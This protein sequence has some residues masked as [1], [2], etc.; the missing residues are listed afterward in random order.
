MQMKV[1]GSIVALLIASLSVPAR[2][3]T[4]K[5]RIEFGGGYLH[6]TGDQ[7][8]DGFD[9]SAAAIFSRRVSIEFDYDGIY[10][11]SKIGVFELNPQVGLTTSKSHLQNFIIGPHISF[12]A[13]AIRKT[14]NL[15]PFVDAQFGVSHL[16]S[17]LSSVTLGTTSNS[18]TAFSWM[19]GG[20]ADYR[21]SPHWRARAKLDFL[22]T[23]F[24]SA[25]QSRLRFGLG[26]AY[27]FRSR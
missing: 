12:P 19:L 10:D 27:T 4:T 17:E 15:I 13:F 22:R 23:H 21:L 5:A 25:G 26:V 6:V 7:G 1:F 20:G 8:L 24:A 14:K 18:D 11:T 9:V 3:Q 16:N 2:A